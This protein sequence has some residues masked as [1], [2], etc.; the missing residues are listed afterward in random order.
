LP[1]EAVR[2]RSVAKPAV[3]RRYPPAE[4][5]R[6][7]L[8]AAVRFFAEFGFV[9][10]TRQL[11]ERLGITQPLLFNYF[12]T[13]DALI[14]EVYRRVYLARFNPE[15]ER[16]LADRSIP[17][18]DR[19]V[20]VYVAYAKAIDRYE[21]I[22]IFMYSGLRGESIS[23]RYMKRMHN[24]VFTRICIELRA[25]CGYPLPPNGRISPLEY[26]L[27]YMLTGCLTYLLI[28]RWIYDMPVKADIE[29]IMVQN[30]ETFLAG[31]EMM[32]PRIL[33]SAKTKPARSRK[34]A[35]A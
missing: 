35:G 34:R 20:R 11:A 17:L 27:V 28:R 9:G 1:K 33:A 18:R 10:Q 6:L 16:I 23:R 13:K 24:R 8:E 7:I 21:W 14:D 15:W 22:R 2:K 5:K 26:E 31:A 3:R 4:R 30:V 25:H 29:D 32:L 12:P 19:L